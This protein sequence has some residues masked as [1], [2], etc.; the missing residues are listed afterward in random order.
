MTELLQSHDKTWMDEDLL[1]MD[2]QRKWFLGMESN[3]G[4]HAL[5]TVE[6][7]TK[8]SEYYINL[9]D[10]AA[11]RFERT[12]TLKEIF[13]QEKCYQTLQALEKSFKKKKEF[14]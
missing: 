12:L 2:E 5:K 14:N 1:P 13:L 10:K 4:E 11:A 8:G 3:P 9:V 7:T 6:M